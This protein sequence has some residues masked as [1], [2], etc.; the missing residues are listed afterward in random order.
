MVGA[1]PPAPDDGQIQQLLD[2][3]VR[4]GMTVADIGAHAGG[5][6]IQMAARAELVYAVEPNPDI[7]NMLVENTR[8]L[9]NV[10]VLRM[11]ALDRDGSVGLWL[12]DGN[13]GDTRVYGDGQ[14][15]HRVKCRRIAPFITPLDFALLDCQGTEHLALRGMGAKRPKVCVV[16]M[17]PEGLAAQGTNEERV[18]AEYRRMRYEVTD[19]ERPVAGYWNLL[20][21]KS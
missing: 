20:L 1:L 21:R 14:P 12:N 4:P 5:Y 8:G 13:T 9:E 10:K 6:V 2:E 18:L 15:A 19:L 3:H 7:Y 17:W 16:E 11:A